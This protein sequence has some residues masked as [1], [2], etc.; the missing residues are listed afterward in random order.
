M[1]MVA[2]HCMIGTQAVI[3]LHGPITATIT[4]HPHW[5]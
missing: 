3:Q 4:L 5:A 2:P 1:V